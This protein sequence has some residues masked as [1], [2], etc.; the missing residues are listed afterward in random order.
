MHSM[1]EFDARKLYYFIWVLY[2]DKALSLL[3]NNESNRLLTMQS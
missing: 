3:Y 2:M 1:H